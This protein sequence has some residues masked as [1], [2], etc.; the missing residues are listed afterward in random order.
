MDP[1]S[2]LSGP[3]DAAAFVDGS[4]TASGAKVMAE[5]AQLL[6]KTNEI[7]TG[8]T[9]VAGD[10]DTAEGAIQTNAANIAGLTPDVADHEDRIAALEVTAGNY[11]TTVSVSSNTSLTAA[12]CLSYRVIIDVGGSLIT[13]P[14]VGVADDL[15]ACGPITILNAE[16]GAGS[17]VAIQSGGKWGDGTTSAN[18]FSMTSEEWLTVVPVASTES[19]GD[20]VWY[21]IGGLTY[22][23]K[24][25]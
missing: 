19:A 5:V 14:C 8:L 4:A 2:T 20:V 23:D 13:L 1:I 25:S 22:A 12:Q 3:V 11:G 24:S 21:L 7:V 9:V 15:A 18:S 17:V 10:L 6:N 16:G